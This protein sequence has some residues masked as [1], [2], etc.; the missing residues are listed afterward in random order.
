MKRS[1]LL[2]AAIVAPIWIVMILCTHWEP[3]MRDGWGHFL[4]HQHEPMSLGSVIEFAKGAYTHNNPRLGQVVTYLQFTPGPWHPLVTP[5]GELATFYLLTALVLGRWPS[6]RRPDDGLLFLVLFAMTAVTAPEFGLMLFYRPF[7]GNYVFGLLV[8]LAFLVPYRFAYAEAR[9]RAWWWVAIMVVLGVASGLCNEHTGPG[10][11]AAAMAATYACWRRDRTITW[12]QLAGILGMIVGGI[13]LFKAPGQAIRYNGLANQGSMIGRVLHRGVRAT[14][15]V[16]GLLVKY[17]TPAL[18]WCVVAVIARLRGP[19]S[20]P[21]PAS[22]RWTEIALGATSLLIILTL[23]ASPKVGTRLYFG[24]VALACAAIAGVVVRQL[25]TRWAQVTAGVLA[26]GVII[27]VG[28]KCLS[29][30][31]QLGPEFEARLEK[32]GKA[33]ANSVLDLPS[34][35]VKRSRWSFDD[36]LHIAQIRNLVASSFSL[37]MIQIDGVGVADI[38]VPDEP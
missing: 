30:Y 14:L 12:W 19:A 2:W 5:I 8:N 13:A 21:A 17:L 7:T 26:A 24:S 28:V 22:R 15:A 16:I 36:D 38:P 1:Y 18:P 9:T 29:A 33:P 34:Y 37:A 35:T 23:L 6:P 31:H 11:V 25:S 4:M 32:L 27:F 20:E 3:V 10:I